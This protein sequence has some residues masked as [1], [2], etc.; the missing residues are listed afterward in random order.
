MAITLWRNRRPFEGLTSWFDDMERWFDTGLTT[1][2]PE[3]DV[4]TCYRY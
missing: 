1:D 2:L 4:E 3:S